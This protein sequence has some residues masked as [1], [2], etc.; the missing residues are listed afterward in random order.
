MVSLWVNSPIAPKG[1]VSLYLQLGD[2]RSNGICNGLQGDL[3]YLLHIVPERKFEVIGGDAAETI[4]SEDEAA[5]IQV[6]G[7]HLSWVIMGCWCSHLLGCFMRTWKNLWA[8]LHAYCKHG[9]CASSSLKTRKGLIS[10]D[11]L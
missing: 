2:E 1:S 5:E 8:L 7:S 11:G 9:N 4:V 6:V 10:G 3:L